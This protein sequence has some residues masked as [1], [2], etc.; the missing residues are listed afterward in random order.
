MVCDCSAGDDLSQ[1][2]HG[3]I[4]V[5]AQ[6]TSNS[7]NLGRDCSEEVYNNDKLI[8]KVNRKKMRS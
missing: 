1:S 8:F 4:E 2:H 5:N 6:L 3:G 7:E